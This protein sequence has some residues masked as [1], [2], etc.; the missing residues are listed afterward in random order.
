MKIKLVA[1]ARV[2]MPAG[3][4][5]ELADSVAAQYVR[6]GLAVELKTVRKAVKEPAE[7]KN[8]TK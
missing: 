8:K 2:M 4:E 1:P 3:T 6:A 7:K 5:L